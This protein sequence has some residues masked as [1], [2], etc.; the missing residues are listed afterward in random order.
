MK[1]IGATPGYIRGPFLFE[2]ALYGVVA[3]TFSYATVTAVL[4]ALG[5]STTFLSQ[6]AVSNTIDLYKSNWI[7]VYF[8]TIAIGALIGLLSSLLAISKHLKLKRW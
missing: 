6:I 5:K 7:L 3:G 2:A 8:A 1:L 4:V